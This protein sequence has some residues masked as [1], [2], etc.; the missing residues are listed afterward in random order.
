MTGILS[1]D[2]IDVSYG[3]T[4][5]INDLSLECAEDDILAVLGRNGMGKTTLLKCL[6]GVLSAN[7][8]TIRFDDTQITDYSAHERA[9]LGITLVPQGRDIFPDL[10]VAENLRMGTFA[11]VDREPPDREVVFEYFPVLE[12]RLNQ[13]GGTLSGGQ[14]Q[15]LAI[16]RGLMTNPRLMLLDEPSEGIQP[17]IVNQIGDIIAEI[18]EQEGIPIVLVEQNADL[19]FSVADRGYIIENGQV[20]EERSIAALQDDQLLKDR[21]GI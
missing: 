5:V 6:A 16:G 3:E 20:V 1:V 10:T 2:S 11:A 19:V 18:H 7:A 14:Q 4:R 17:S 13:K 8:G 12:E 15:M 9:A 21:I